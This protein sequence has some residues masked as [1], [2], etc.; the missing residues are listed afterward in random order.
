MTPVLD[1]EAFKTG[2]AS[3]S[4]GKQQATTRLQANRLGRGARFASGRAADDQDHSA[5]VLSGEEGGPQRGVAVA[6]DVVEVGGLAGEVSAR[7][8]EGAEVS[9]GD[10]E[11]GSVRAEGG[12][13]QHVSEA[14][15]A[16]SMGFERQRQCGVVL[17][18][19][20]LLGSQRH[21]DK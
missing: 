14:L 18:H 12:L 6:L 10:P 3:D 7:D 9:V 15:K 4:G 21:C 13:L 17:G 20:H 11:W 2:Q 8:S 19:L 1:R 5:F 16:V